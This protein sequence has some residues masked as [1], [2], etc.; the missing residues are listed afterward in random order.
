MAMPDAQRDDAAQRIEITPPF[1]VEDVLALPLDQ[2]DRIFVIQKQRRIQKFLAQLQHLVR[3]RTGIRLRLM[4]EMRQ[5]R[6]FHFYKVV[7]GPK[8]F[9]R[10]IPGK[11]LRSATAPLNLFFDP[12]NRGE[13]PARTPR[14]RRSCKAR[15]KLAPRWPPA[16]S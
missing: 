6:C 9:G 7:I 13:S 1:F 5:G 2:H 10:I 11:V 16:K 12:A 3:G 14:T 15:E 4:R 8:S